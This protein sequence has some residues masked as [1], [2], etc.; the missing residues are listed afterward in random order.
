MGKVNG[1]IG[2][3]PELMVVYY[4]SEVSKNEVIVLCLNIENLIK[5]ILNVCCYFTW[6]EWW[7]SFQADVHQASLSQVY[8]LTLPCQ[9]NIL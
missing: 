7:V 8:K 2:L 3:K 1:K 4:A 9:T 5:A 6:A